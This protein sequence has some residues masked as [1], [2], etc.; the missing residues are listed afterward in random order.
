MSFI[1][2]WSA[3]SWNKWN[4]VTLALALFMTRHWFPYFL[5]ILLLYISTTKS[6]L[7]TNMYYSHSPLVCVYKSF[8]HI[9]VYGGGRRTAACP[10]CCGSA[11]RYGPKNHDWK[12]V[13]LFCYTDTQ[14]NALV[15]HRTPHSFLPLRLYS[16][17]YWAWHYTCYIRKINGKQS[18]FLSFGWQKKI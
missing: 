4:F 5:R 14:Q 3:A 8:T 11:S 7:Y 15:D 10:G 16:Q 2:S 12:P 18:F 13:W 1:S 17:W 9:R 6:Y